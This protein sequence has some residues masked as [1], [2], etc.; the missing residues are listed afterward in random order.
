MIYG[1][2]RDTTAL[3]PDE[4][5]VLERLCERAAEA[6]TAIEL[7]ALRAVSAAPQAFASLEH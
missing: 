5:A 2:H 4:I 6:Y 1:T 3:D 7:A